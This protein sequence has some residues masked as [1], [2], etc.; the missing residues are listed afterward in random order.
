MAIKTLP[1]P[2]EVGRRGKTIYD[3]KLRDLV[4]TDENIGKFLSLDIDTGDYEIGPDRMDTTGR[5]LARN[6]DAEIYTVRIGY[7]AVGAIGGSLLRT[8]QK[9]RS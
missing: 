6:S 3:E 4:E 2:E 9:G 5:L 7:R 8:A 1:S